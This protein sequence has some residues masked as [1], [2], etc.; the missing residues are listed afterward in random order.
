MIHHIAKNIVVNEYADKCE[1][2][3]LYAIGMKELLSIYINT[4]ETEK[5]QMKNW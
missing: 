4:F 3:V 5:N 2:Q 1:T